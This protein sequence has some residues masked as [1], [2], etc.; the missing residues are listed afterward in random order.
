MNISNHIGNTQATLDTQ[1]AA[2][3]SHSKAEASKKSTEDHAPLVPVLKDAMHLSSAAG[4]LSPSSSA[5]EVPSERV[6]GLQAAIASGTYS[7]SSS[8]VAGKLIDSLI[9]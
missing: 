5:A 9:R 2:P 4:I 7:V 8:D 6:A 1:A 3:V